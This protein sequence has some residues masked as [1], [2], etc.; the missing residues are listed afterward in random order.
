[1]Q[2][3]I[4]IQDG[5][6]TLYLRRISPYLAYGREVVTINREHQALGV[7]KCTP[8]REIVVADQ[9]I[10]FEGYY[11]HYISKGWKRISG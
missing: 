6:V 11:K 5:S 1:M 7:H 8:Q 3:M 4:Q 10:V 2:N 9:K